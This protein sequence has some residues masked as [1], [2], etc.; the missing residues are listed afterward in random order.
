MAMII[1][2]LQASPRVNITFE[3]VCGLIKTF[4][5]I[6]TNK[7]RLGLVGLFKR[8][9][10]HSTA[11]P[12][13]QHLN[14][15]VTSLRSDRVLRYKSILTA[16]LQDKPGLR[17]TKA[18]DSVPGIVHPQKRCNKPPYQAT[19]CEVV[20]HL[21]SLLSHFSMAIK[22]TRCTSSLFILCF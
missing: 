3:W 11:L 20:S 12:L 5:P 6:Q 9:Q 18:K 2:Y 7:C 10:D 22:S 8:C 16:I 15:H 13:Q 19:L 4:Y 1:F 17:E 21:I 14:V